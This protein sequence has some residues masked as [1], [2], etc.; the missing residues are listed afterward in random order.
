MVVAAVFTNARS[1]AA[2]DGVEVGIFRI[3]PQIRILGAYDDQQDLDGDFYGEAEASI[4]IENT[5]AKYDLGGYAHYGY[6]TYDKY[7]DANDDF[8][9]FGGMVASRQTPLKLGLEAYQ[10]KTIDYDAQVQDGSADGLG[11]IW[12]S[13]DS[14]RT[15]VE[16]DAAY[17][18][19]LTDKSALLS[20]Y[21]G[22]YYKQDF[23]SSPEVEWNEHVASLRLGYS[24]TPRTLLTLLGSYSLQFS[25]EEDGNIATVLVGAESIRSE[26]L[27]WEA[28]VGISAADYDESGTDEGFAGLLNVR[29][30]A[31]DKIF[32]Y[33]F[34]ES[35][36]QPG[37]V[38][39][40]ALQSY[41]AG[42]GCEWAMIERVRLNAQVLHD[43][44][45]AIDSD[46]D[47]TTHFVS[48]DIEYDVA[49]RITL[50]VGG[51]YVFEEGEED[52]KVV[53]FSAIFAY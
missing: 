44:Q 52:E 2:G 3:M 24:L 29:W 6:R 36:Y 19:Q 8:Y 7:S 26:K 5:E 16:F 42:Y 15:S 12:T 21:D 30:R 35:R 11:E 48:G 40:G 22:R 27:T 31:T 39:S 1:R 33:V 47:E 49:D 34:G 4:E 17:E 28:L 32:T 9:G 18:I 23:D 45:K 37:N 53:R 43:R 51:R 14:T 38:R 20:G 41:R 13:E 50:A 46:R 10:R 25:D